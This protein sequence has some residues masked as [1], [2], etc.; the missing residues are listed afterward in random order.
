MRN[1]LRIKRRSDVAEMN[2]AICEAL[3]IDPK[4]IVAMT[5]QVQK[6]EVPRITVT[7]SARYVAEAMEGMSDGTW[8]GQVWEY[9]LVPVEPPEL[10]VPAQGADWVVPPSENGTPTQVARGT[11]HPRVD[12]MG[13]P[14]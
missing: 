12:G 14:G 10:A 7:Y 1:P 6:D 2:V 8:L 3:G 4:G 9:Q 11:H 5:V 13:R